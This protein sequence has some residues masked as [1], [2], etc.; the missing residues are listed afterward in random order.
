MLGLCHHV[1]PGHTASGGGRPGGPRGGGALFQSGGAFGGSGQIAERSD[2]QREEIGFASRAADARSGRVERIGGRS[3]RRERGAERGREVVGRR[4][5]TGGDGIGEQIAGRPRPRSRCLGQARGEVVP[6]PLAPST[7]DAGA[8]PTC[9][10]PGACCSSVMVCSM[11]ANETGL[12]VIA[13]VAAPG[14]CALWSGR[15]ARRLRSGRARPATA[16]DGARPAARAW[17]CAAWR[18]PMPA[19]PG[20]PPLLPSPPHRHCGA[21]SRTSGRTVRGTTPLFRP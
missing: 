2:E 12:M 18:S 4:I 6:D 5:G 10:T 17:P 16:S 9:A 20:V 8:E 21:T 15:R 3:R 11:S 13:L 7:A 1:R 19:W 14:P